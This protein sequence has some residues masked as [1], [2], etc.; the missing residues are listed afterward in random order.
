MCRWMLLVDIDCPK[1]LRTR[2]NH[3]TLYVFDLPLPMSERIASTTLSRVSW[4][5]ESK[6]GRIRINLQSVLSL[7]AFGLAKASV[8]LMGF[9]LSIFPNLIPNH[10]LAHDCGQ[11]YVSRLILLMCINVVIEAVPNLFHSVL[12]FV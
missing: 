6:F 1:F 9:L 10:E 5:C 11:D 7:P 3:E 4:S 2:C 12:N 8:R